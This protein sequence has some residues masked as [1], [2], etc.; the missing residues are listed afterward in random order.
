[1]NPGL[2]WKFR[3]YCALDADKLQKQMNVSPVLA[4]LLVQ[5]G[6]KSGEDT[7]SFFNK[8]LDALSEPF[9]L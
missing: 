3:E 7:Y 1:M 6:I 2:I 8:N 5:R 9:A 4:K